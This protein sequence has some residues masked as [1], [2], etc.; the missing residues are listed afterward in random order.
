MTWIDWA[1][2]STAPRH[3]MVDRTTLT[4]QQP[5]NNVVRSTIQCLGGG[6]DH[7]VERLLRGER[8]P[9]VPREEPEPGRGQ[10]PVLLGELGD[11]A[12]RAA[13]AQQRGPVHHPGTGWWTGPRC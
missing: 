3:W 1:P 13:A 4:A 2:P 9:R 10:A 8:G 7:V 6:P 11:H 5:L 12:H